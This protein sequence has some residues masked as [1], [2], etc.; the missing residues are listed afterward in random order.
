MEYPREVVE[1]VE[2]V[3]EAAE[4]VAEEAFLLQYRRNQQLPMEEIN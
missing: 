1:E 4:E 3:E 2:E